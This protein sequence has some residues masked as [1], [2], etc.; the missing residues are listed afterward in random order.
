MVVTTKN[1]TLAPFIPETG[2][3]RLSMDWLRRAFCYRENFSP[4]PKILKH[5][6]SSGG[7]QANHG[8]M[9]HWETLAINTSLFLSTAF[10]T[11]APWSMGL[12]TLFPLLLFVNLLLFLFL[13]L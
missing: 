4:A 12:T 7:Q 5:S 13:R 6:T 11:R 1:Y 3:C 8:G 2:D 9:V 10:S